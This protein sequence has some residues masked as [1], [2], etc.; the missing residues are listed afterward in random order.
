M[1]EFR[2]IDVLIDCLVYP[3]ETKVYNIDELTQK[4]PITRICQLIYRMLSHCVKDNA[5]N[6]NYVAQWI[7]L[8]FTQ[9]IL[10]TEENSFKAEKTIADLLEDNQMLLEN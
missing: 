10:T 4:H 2:L 8:F 7:D 9:A 1:R 3:F 5:M 6:K